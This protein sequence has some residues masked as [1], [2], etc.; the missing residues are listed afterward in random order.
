MPFVVDASMAASW[1]L[2]DEKR[3]E[4][5]R[6]YARLADDEALVPY[7]W[8]YEIR[9]LFIIAERR[10]RIDS[11]QTRVALSLLSRLPIKFDHESLESALLYLARE[12]RLTAYDAAYLELAA[13]Y[14]LPL[15]TL[16]HALAV[17]ARAEKITLIG[18]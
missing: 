13:R 7:L 14:T 11:E 9:N 6:A 2:P 3:P 17:A 15:A 10:G 12:H 5:S 4:A 18:D 1:L 8:W 16:D